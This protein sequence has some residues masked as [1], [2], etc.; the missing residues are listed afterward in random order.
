MEMLQTRHVLGR[1]LTWGV[2]IVFLTASGCLQGDSLLPV[3]ETGQHQFQEGQRYADQQNWPKAIESFSKAIEF[4][5]KAYETYL[6]YATAR[7]SSS[8][9][10]PD[11]V[12]RQSEKITELHAAC[13][14]YYIAVGDVQLKTGNLDGAIGEFSNAIR[15][16]TNRP[17]AYLRRA[18]AYYLKGDQEKAKADAERASR[19]SA[20]K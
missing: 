20:G 2:S 13:Y 5:R 8:H 11:V 3:P 1:R 18:D 15:I 4:N 17:E 10:D 12:R 19:Q 16:N 6:E 9:S 14:V 7:L